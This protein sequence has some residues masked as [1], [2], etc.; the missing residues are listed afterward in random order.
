[1]KKTYN[2]PTM[3]VVV[4]KHRPSLLAGSVQTNLSGYGGWGGTYDDDDEA[5]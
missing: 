1:M 2:K 3:T 4:T 5:D